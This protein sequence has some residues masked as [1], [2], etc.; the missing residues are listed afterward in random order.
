M[1]AE[2]HPD[3]KE[4]RNFKTTNT[5][6]KSCRLGEMLPKNQNDLGLHDIGICRKVESLHYSV[7]NIK[8][9]VMISIK[10]GNVFTAYMRRF[11]NLVALYAT[12]LLKSPA[13]Q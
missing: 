9:R 10:G 3:E 7:S 13:P 2:Q 5:Y 11:C 4:D 8:L 6:S 1:I 12:L